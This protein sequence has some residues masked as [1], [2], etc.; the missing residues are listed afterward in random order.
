[1]VHE[2]GDYEIRL[3][4]W[5]E[6]ADLAMNASLPAGA[7]VPG[8][9]AYR[10]T[11]GKGIDPVKATLK[12]GSASAESEVS[13]GDKEVVFNLSLKKGK[14]R[15]SALFISEDGEEHGAYYAYVMKK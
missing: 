11:P 8:L 4:R 6:T 10:T 12:I 13:A 5:P 9:K 2:D 1:M 3:R 7:D 14:T 15:M